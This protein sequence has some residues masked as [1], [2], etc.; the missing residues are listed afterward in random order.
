MGPLA[1]RGGIL[2]VFLVMAGSAR[3][4][5][6]RAPTVLLQPGMMTADFVS[7]PSGEP[8]TTG[9]NLRFSGVVPT[10]W[11]WLTLMVGG[12]VTP[13]GSSGASRRN[14]NTPVLFVGNV[15]PV[16]GA[17]RTAGWLS[18]DAPLL[19]TYTFGGGGQH[20]PRVYGRDVALGT[21]V[22]VHVGRRL[23]SGF[24]GPLARLRL[25]GMLEQTLTPNT[26]FEGTRDRF[27]PVAYYGVTLPFG[28]GRA[29]P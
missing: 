26:T 16:L 2:A 4:Q 6:P 15:F 23:L 10:R 12:S 11:P 7:A 5:D 3:A 27:N 20:N 1:I 8:A 9:F 28:T 19:L 17:G 24:D 22:T 29:S 14:T 18:L 21:S 13:Y 25:Y